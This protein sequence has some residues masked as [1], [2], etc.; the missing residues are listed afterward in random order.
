MDFLETVRARASALARRLAFPES[1][2]ER[3]LE[4]V[5]VLRREKVVEPVLVLDPTRPESH[6]AVRATGALVVDPVTDP[7]LAAAAALLHER[8]QAKGMTAAE[9]ARLVRSPLM[10]ADALVALGELDG[11]VAG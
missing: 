9:A 2:D 11:C 5:R 8:R 3:T 7:R 10:F 1:A 6:D 4:A